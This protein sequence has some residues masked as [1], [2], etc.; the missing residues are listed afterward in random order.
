MAFSMS[1]D[2]SDESINKLLA[3]DSDIDLNTDITM[4]SISLSDQIQRMVAK[5]LDLDTPKNLSEHGSPSI[6]NDSIKQV[7][8]NMSSNNHYQESSDEH[9]PVPTELKLA[10][11]SEKII[12]T[13]SE[14]LTSDKVASV[15]STKKSTPKEES[16][17]T[18]PS[19][20]FHK[21]PTH[22]SLTPQS[23]F[24]QSPRTNTGDKEAMKQQ[25]MVED[26]ESS[27]PLRESAKQTTD[28]PSNRSLSSARSTRSTQSTD[29]SS[30]SQSVKT[31]SFIPQIDPELEKKVM[32]MQKLNKAMLLK[33]KKYKNSIFEL[34]EKNKV[35]LQ[36]NMDLVSEIKKIKKR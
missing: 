12:S 11:Y 5:T 29:R 35:L 4:D 18:P 13:V 8:V 21:S 14:K 19:P 24:Y 1:P 25:Y 6:T 30:S 26:S 15:F 3:S 33:L 36:I 10:Q 27:L 20:S 16:P 9:E 32:R 28:S 22:K 34:E 2:S 17:P 23:E 7:S 31:D